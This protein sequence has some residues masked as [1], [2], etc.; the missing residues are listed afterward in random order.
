MRRDRVMTKCGEPSCGRIIAEFTAAGASPAAARAIH[1]VCMAHASRRN[2]TSDAGGPPVPTEPE[3]H[4]AS[5][6]VAPLCSLFRRHLRALGLKYTPERAGVLDAVIERDQPFEVEELLADFAAQDVAISKAT[7]Y[8]TIKL[9][10]EAGL[11]IPLV[12]DGRQTHYQLV[13]GQMTRDVLVCMRSGRIIEFED[14]ALSDAARR[15]AE[16]FGWDVVSH[17]MHIFGVAPADEPPAASAAKS[18]P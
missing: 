7:I 2:H 13:H 17:R 10:Q 14:Q 8:R 11:I 5:L 6:A 18:T 3:A 16:A 15:I 1:C 4:A 9:L 12:R